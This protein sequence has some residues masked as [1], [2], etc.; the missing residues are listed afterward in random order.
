MNE[1]FMTDTV[2]KEQ[3]WRIDYGTYQLMDDR[4]IS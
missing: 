4:T 1:L 2:L 3:Y